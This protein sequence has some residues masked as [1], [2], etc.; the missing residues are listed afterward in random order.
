[1]FGRAVAFSEHVF[2]DRMAATRNAGQ[3]GAIL[4]KK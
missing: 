2:I 1:M 4:L 3:I